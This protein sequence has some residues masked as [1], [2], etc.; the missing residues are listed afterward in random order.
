[1]AYSVRNATFG[2]TRA[3]RGT[4]NG[5]LATTLSGI[6]QG[7]RNTGWNTPKTLETPLRR[8]PERS[9][10]ILVTRP[11]APRAFVAG[12]PFHII[13]SVRELL[14]RECLHISHDHCS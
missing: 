7:L 5:I 6:A 1:R 8:A 10:V 14:L 3:A 4:V 9:T 12:R 13:A 11:P 2:S